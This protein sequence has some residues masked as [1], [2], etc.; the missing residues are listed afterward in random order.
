MVTCK[1]V[2]VLVPVGNLFLS[3]EYDA[4][5]GGLR[6]VSPLPT[7]GQSESEQRLTSPK[8]DITVEMKLRHSEIPQCG[9]AIDRLSDTV[10]PVI[11][12]PEL[13][14]PCFTLEAK[15]LESAHFSTL[16]NTH[17][18]AHVVR[19]LESLRSTA[20]SA[21]WGTNFYD[22]VV[23]LSASI[24]KDKVGIYGHWASKGNGETELYSR[25]MK[26][27]TSE[28]ED[29]HEIHN[30]ISTA[31]FRLLEKNRP[32]IISDIEKVSV[33]TTKQPIQIRT[34]H[35]PKKQNGPYLPISNVN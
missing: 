15:G 26:T 10:T 5:P 32:W 17:N 2:T 1:V 23:A 8:P 28:Y 19:N 34:F 4:V 13:V 11:C 25:A 29:Y 31:I 27:W 24:T 22:H 9:F 33:I 20:N 6:R 18:A 21:D 14:C 7:V 12:R 3:S 30:W 16:Q 35:P